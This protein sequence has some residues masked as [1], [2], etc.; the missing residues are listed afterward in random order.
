MNTKEIKVDKFSLFMM[1]NKKGK[2][3]EKYS[4]RKS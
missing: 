1:K 2:V 4:A 3:I